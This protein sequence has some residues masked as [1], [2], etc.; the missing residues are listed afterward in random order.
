M[1]NCYIDCSAI[2]KKL[3]SYSWET[4]TQDKGT[5]F[6]LHNNESTIQQQIGYKNYWKGI[7]PHT[8]TYHEKTSHLNIL[9]FILQHQIIN[10]GTISKWKIAYLAISK[11]GT[12][13]AGR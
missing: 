5:G 4:H 13:A 9:A 6:V 11:A 12:H 7:T 8:H 1:N 2:F 10:L 3:F